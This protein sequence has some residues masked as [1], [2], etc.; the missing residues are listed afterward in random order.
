M[1]QKLWYGIMLICLI[2]TV[3][4]TTTTLMP[5]NQTNTKY[6]NRLV[7]GEPFGA[8][9][10]IYEDTVGRF[11]W[12]FIL[13]VLWVSL[14]VKQQNIVTPTI[15]VDL[16]AWVL[17]QNVTN[18]FHYVGGIFIAAINIMAFFITLHKLLS[19]KYVD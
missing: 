15:A 7:S 4:A 11:F 14:A 16:V 12:I 19:P 5:L 10:D 1:N 9:E 8:V 18:P 3:S 13:A 6:L 2:N 17:I